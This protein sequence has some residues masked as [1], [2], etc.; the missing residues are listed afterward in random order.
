M[1]L[2]SD[3]TIIYGMWEKSGKPVKNI[4]RRD[5]KAATAYNT[6]TVKALPKGPIANP[7]RAAMAATINPDVSDYL[8][9]VSKND[10]THVFTTKYEDHLKAVKKFQLDRAARKGKSWRDLKNRKTAKKDK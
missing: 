10:G 9:F 4:R 3:P 7:G 2:Q 6:Y 1:R 8:Y 5:I